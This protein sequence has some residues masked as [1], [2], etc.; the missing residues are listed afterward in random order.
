MPPKRSAKRS[1]DGPARAGKKPAPS[2]AVALA[3]FADLLGPTL[4]PKAFFE[5]VWE[6][7]HC[8]IRSED[9]GR[10][11]AMAS[12]FSLKDLKQQLADPEAIPRFYLSVT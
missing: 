5:E 2:A 8:H 3:S 11:T 1:S 4:S 9:A 7:R 12:L 6:Q 10:A